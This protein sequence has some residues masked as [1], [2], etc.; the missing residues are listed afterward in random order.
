MNEDNNCLGDYYIN[1][2]YTIKVIFVNL[3]FKTLNSVLIQIK[4]Q[5]YIKY[6]I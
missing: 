3:N 1:D 2:G 5:W 4:I 6:Q